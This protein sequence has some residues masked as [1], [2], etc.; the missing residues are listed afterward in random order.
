MDKVSYDWW[1]DMADMEFF[2]WYDEIFTEEE[3]DIIEKLVS[4][5]DLYDGEIAGEVKKDLSVRDSKIKF[6]NSSDLK[7]RWIFE[8]FTG[9]VNNANERFFKFELSRLESLQYT[10]YN[11]GQYYKEHMDMG[12]RNPNN[13]IRKLSFTLQLTNPD[14]YEGGDLIIK[15]G[16]TPDVAR[17]NRGAITFFPSYIMHEVTPVTRGTRK[18][19]VGWVTGPRW[20]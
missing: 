15:H 3:L 1:L 10:V 18:S 19:I 14:E 9:L 7:N 8:R 4:D 16:S 17:K 5:N 12:Y 2:A 6:I 20:K 11:E 13:A